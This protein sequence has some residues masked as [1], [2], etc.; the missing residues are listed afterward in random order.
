MPLSQQHSI[1]E[2]LGNLI[3][4]LM[5]QGRPEDIQKAMELSRLAEK[6]SQALKDANSL[7]DSA[8]L[9]EVDSLFN[10]YS[11]NAEIAPEKGLA[12][13]NRQYHP[14]VFKPGVVNGLG[15]GVEHDGLSAPAKSG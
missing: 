11:T 8:L 10:Q 6:L 15:T 9:Q 5:L 7:T 14:D 13:V 4:S 1:S 3:N 2:L 12:L